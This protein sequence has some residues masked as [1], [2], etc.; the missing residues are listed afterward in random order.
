MTIKNSLEPSASKLCRLA[1]RYVVVHPFVLQYM[2]LPLHSGMRARNANAH[3]ASSTPAISNRATAHK[4]GLNCRSRLRLV[5]RKDHA[6][7]QCQL[8]TPG[9]P[10]F[11]PGQLLF[12][13]SGRSF[14]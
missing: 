9:Q 11:I 6:D 10:L 5:A 13:C 12:I 7:R 1:T 4:L 8:F 2:P 14:I 3:S